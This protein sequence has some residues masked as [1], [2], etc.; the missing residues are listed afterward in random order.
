MK[1]LDALLNRAQQYDVAAYGQIARRFQ[2]MALGYAYAMLGDV[3]LA[4]DAVQEAFIETYIN[5]SRVYGPGAFPAFL[6]KVVFK[7]CDRMIRMRRP[8]VMLDEAP[9]LPSPDT[10]EEDLRRRETARRIHRAIATL[11]LPERQAIVLF[12][13]NGRKRQEIAEFL[14]LPLETVIYRLRSAR[15]KLREEL[16]AV[17]PDRFDEIIAQPVEEAG[18]VAFSEIEAGEVDPELAMF[19]GKLKDASSMGINLL[20]YSLDVAHLAGLIAAEIGLDARLAQRAGLLHDIGKSSPN[21]GSHVERGVEIGSRYDE[22][23]V[24]RDVIATHHEPNSGLTPYA[25]AVKAADVLS[26]Q[27]ESQTL[28]AT[29]PQVIDLESTANMQAVQ[30]AHAV[31]V[32]DEMWVL[33][34]GTEAVDADTVADQIRV[35]LG[36]DIPIL[37]TVAPGVPS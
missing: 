26:V 1:T 36:I 6:R 31:R 23:P 13:I 30:A 9:S 7:H 27:Q 14:D 16:D 33:I 35:A 4:E 25:F 2:D 20:H 22:D 17:N 5:L 3:H 12:H 29:V 10:P 37:V 15:E 11:P 34:R 18:E 8:E 28:E 21:G 19:V 24:I 32:L